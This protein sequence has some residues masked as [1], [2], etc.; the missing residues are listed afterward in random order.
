MDTRRNP[1]NYYENGRQASIT[2][3]DVD[4]LF[5]D[6]LCEQL[7]VTATTTVRFGV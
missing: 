7:V 1:T 5:N 4:R 2:R 3:E 6:A